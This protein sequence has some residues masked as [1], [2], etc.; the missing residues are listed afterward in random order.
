MA[1]TALIVT[2]VCI[3]LFP[4]SA[5]S[6]PLRGNASIDRIHLDGSEDGRILDGETGK[7]IQDGPVK[8]E[9]QKPELDLED[10][11][12]AH[13]D[14]HKGG[15]R[16]QPDWIEGKVFSTDEMHMYSFWQLLPLKKEFR[17]TIPVSKTSTIRLRHNLAEL[18]KGPFKPRGAC[19][20]TVEPVG[21][22]ERFRFYHSNKDGPHGYIEREGTND[23]GFPRYRFWF[24]DNS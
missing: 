14:V 21:G 2:L 9:P 20:V 17:W 23:K 16:K 22:G 11:T 7:L 1:R 19:Q 3:L 12:D 10:P 4:L 24:A 15:I 6:L 5:C 18:W 8:L 13:A